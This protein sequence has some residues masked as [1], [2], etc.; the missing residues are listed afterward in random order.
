[1]PTRRQL[2]WLV[3]HLPDTDAPSDVMALVSELKKE[4][5]LHPDDESFD[6]VAE[7]GRPIYCDA[8]AMA[9]GWTRPR[10]KKR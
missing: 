3:S 4:L 8:M 10:R 9:Y 5:E 6:L 1:M 2:E 7:S